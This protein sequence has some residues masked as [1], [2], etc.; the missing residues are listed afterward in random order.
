MSIRTIPL[1]QLQANPVTTLIECADT[2]VTV[3]VEM[4]GHRLVAIQSLEDVEVDDPLIDN[5]IQN[6]PKF[7]EM[8]ARSK[9][10]GSVPFSI[11]V[12]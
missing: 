7:R 5:L 12:D 2:G 1:S 8:L 4:P 11:D 3:V 10:S 9:A 6:N